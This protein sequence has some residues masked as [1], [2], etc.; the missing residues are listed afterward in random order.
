MIAQTLHLT[1]FQAEANYCARLVLKALSQRGLQAPVS[2][3]LTERNNLVWLAVILNLMD[4]AGRLEGFA[5]PD[6]LHQL[7]TIL[8]GKQVFLSNST[9]LRYLILLTPAPDLPEAIE[10]PL[11]MEREAL[12]LGISLSG[13]I[14]LQ[15]PR[16]MLICGEPGSGKSTLLDCIRYAGSRHGWSLYFVDP[17]GHTF[18]PETLNATAARP[19]AQ[20]PAELLA[21]LEQI[22]AELVR[23][24]ALFRSAAQNGLPPAD[25]TAYNQ[26]SS[27]PLPRMLL[28]VD[29]ANSYFD[30]KAILEKLTDLARRGR[31]WGLSL[32]LAGHNWRAADVP[33]AL[34]AMFPV[35]VSFRVAD[36]TTATVVLGSRRWGKLAQ[37]LRQPGRAVVLVD[38]QYHL[39]QAYRLTTEQSGS[40]AAPA[41]T[42]NPLSPIEQSLIIH[43][44]QHLGGRFIV[45]QLAAAFAGQGVTSHQVKTLAQTWERR[46]WLSTPLHATDARKVTPELA[47]L[48]GL[49]RTGAQA[50]Q[51]NTGGPDLAQVLFQP[52]PVEPA[53]HNPRAQRPS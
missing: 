22:E 5:S 33:R 50:A 23:R 20:S 45:N 47:L 36:D 9:G 29:E 1:R 3:Y 48:A 32:I 10:F 28:L 25:I 27:Q 35:R 14:M 49:P 26:V 53:A 31:K 24:Q 39:I 6:T 8:H 15:S 42:A 7:S 37:K 46:R 4:L 41:L 11:E 34:S 16:N 43:A 19:V 30:S 2:F 17:D 21:L 40:L 18:N 38:G 13:A 44:L 51:G 52:A 12:P